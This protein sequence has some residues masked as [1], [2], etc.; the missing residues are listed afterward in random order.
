MSALAITQQARQLRLP[1]QEWEIA[2]IL[3]IM[4]DQIEGAEDRSVRCLRRR[5]SLIGGLPAVRTVKSESD[6]LYCALADDPRYFSYFEFGSG[7]E[8]LSP[9]FRMQECHFKTRQLALDKPRKNSGLY[10]SF[11]IAAWQPR[12]A[13][14]QDAQSRH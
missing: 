13:V 6:F 8:A 5:D 10:T 2:Q 11:S 9:G 3:T 1:V 4:L 12:S 7:L 14:R